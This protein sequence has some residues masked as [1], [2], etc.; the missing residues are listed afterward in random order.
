MRL[1]HPNPLLLITLS[2]DAFFVAITAVSLATG[3]SVVPGAC[4]IAALHVARWAMKRGEAR[5]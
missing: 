2:A 3:G 5:R 1:H 4:S